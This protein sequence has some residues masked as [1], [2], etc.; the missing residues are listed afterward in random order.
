MPSGVVTHFTS[1]RSASITAT[2]E[3]ALTTGYASDGGLYV[4]NVIPKFT[5]ED[6]VS[7][8]KMPFDD[9][10]YAVLRPYVPSS[11]IPDPDLRS[12]V[13]KAFEPFHS[14]TRVNLTPLGP[15]AMLS[16]LLHS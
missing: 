1:T 6:L 5:K 7:M 15:G 4:P 14:P 16:E 12:I 2:F 10:A 13:R 9:L 11:E 3:T 8:S